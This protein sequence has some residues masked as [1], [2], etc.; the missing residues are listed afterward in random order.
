VIRADGVGGDLIAGQP[1]SAIAFEID[2]EVSDL[3]ILP[4][5]LVLLLLLDLPF[6]RRLPEARVLEDEMAKGVASGDQGLNSLHS[7][8][9]LGRG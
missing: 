9:F 3:P 6:P 2:V 1:G 8:L 5:L 4:E 7:L